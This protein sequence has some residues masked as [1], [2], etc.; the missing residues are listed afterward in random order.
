MRQRN[1]LKKLG[2]C[3]ILSMGLFLLAGCEAESDKSEDSGEFD[4]NP[5]AEINLSD[6]LT[7]PNYDEYIFNP[8]EYSVSE[9]EVDDEIEKKLLEAGTS[10]TVT[11]GIVE[12]GDKINIIFWGAHRNY[13]NCRALA[14]YF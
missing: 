13:W 11:E 9:Q 3:I 12:M 1:C 5:Y 7:L 4:I 6:Y 8:V 14:R 10:E 2:V